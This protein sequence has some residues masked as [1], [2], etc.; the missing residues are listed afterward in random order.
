[1]RPAFRVSAGPASWDLEGESI[2]FIESSLQVISGQ[3][4]QEILALRAHTVL[5]R[6]A[7]YEKNRDNDYIRENV[8]RSA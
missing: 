8:C 5:D 1:M 7:V 6:W 4:A 3:L 2:K